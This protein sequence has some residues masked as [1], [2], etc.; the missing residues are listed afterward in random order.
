MGNEQ[1]KLHDYWKARSGEGKKIK[2]SSIHMANSIEHLLLKSVR[3]LN[4]DE[5]LEL[6][7]QVT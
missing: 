5:N 4:Y 6:Q 1:E 2:R 3:L 7:L